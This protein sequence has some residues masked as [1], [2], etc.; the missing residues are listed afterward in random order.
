MVPPGIEKDQNLEDPQV[1]SRPNAGASSNACPN[2]FGSK[3]ART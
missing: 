1:W 2:Y 3:V